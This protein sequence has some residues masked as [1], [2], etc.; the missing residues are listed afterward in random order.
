MALPSLRRLALADVDADVPRRLVDHGEDLLVERK[1]IFESADAP[2]IV[3]DAGA[4]Y[5]RSA[6]GR[7]PVTDH[8]TLLEMARRGE[9]AETRARVRLHD[10]LIVAQACAAPDS[11]TQHTRQIHHLAVV[12]RASPLTVTPQLADRPISIGGPARIEQL[13]PWIAHGV[14]QREMPQD[15]DNVSE[16]L[17][18][19][20]R[21]CVAVRRAQ[22]AMANG[23]WSVAMAADSLGVLG[24]RIMLPQGT[25]QNQPPLYVIR[26]QLVRPAVEAITTT[27]AAWEGYGRAAFDVWFSLP[28]NWK[29][30]EAP[31]PVG[32]PGREIHVAG[33]LTI[34]ADED[35]WAALGRQWER[36]LAR[37]LGVARCEGAEHDS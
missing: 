29:A 10:S 26:R 34:A 22:L 36:E 9:E 2:H 32:A 14:W 35:E 30:Q 5:V 17:E 3:R 31:R 24:V 7:E 18:P 11:R 6:K 1:R 28:S 33:E 20:G 16:A 13:L 27:L 15:E 37:H 19:R 8:R 21:G 25:V 4:V 23:E 12:V